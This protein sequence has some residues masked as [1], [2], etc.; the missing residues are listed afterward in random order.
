MTQ[1]SFPCTLPES[2]LLLSWLQISVFLSSQKAPLKI[3]FLPGAMVTNLTSHHFFAPSCFSLFICLIYFHHMA[4]Y[5]LKQ[6]LGRFSSI[7]SNGKLSGAQILCPCSHM[8]GGKIITVLKQACML[9]WKGFY[10]FADYACE[11]NLCICMNTSVC[12]CCWTVVYFC[13]LTLYFLW[14]M[15]V[16]TCWSIHFNCFVIPSLNILISY[17]HFLFMDLYEIFKIF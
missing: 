17:M 2:S 13:H 11:H 7:L 3:H 16:N 12:I 6:T 15:K 10:N 14:S 5:G 9:L 8:E 4:I 1:H